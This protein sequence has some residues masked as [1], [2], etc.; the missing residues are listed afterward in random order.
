MAEELLSPSE[1]A[2]HDRSVHDYPKL[3]FDQNEFVVIDVQRTFMGLVTIWLFAILG[4]ILA[5]IL[6]LVILHLPNL[7]YTDLASCGVISL[8]AIISLTY[9]LIASSV[10]TAN[11]FIVTNKRVFAHIQYTPFAMRTQTIELSRIEDCS[12]SQKGLL[13]TLFDYGSIRLSTVGHEQTYRFS[14]VD[15]PKKQFAVINKYLSKINS[16]PNS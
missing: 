2:D 4:F 14:F 16:S 10:Y 7:T 5:L 1:Q 11:T 13:A 3:D 12:V 6:A 9:G 8:G 15:Q